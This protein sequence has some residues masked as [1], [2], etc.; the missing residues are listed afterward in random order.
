MYPAFPA[1]PALQPT[2]PC[3][4]PSI[5]LQVSM[6]ILGDLVSLPLLSAMQDLVCSVT[7][8]LDW[9]SETTTVVHR[10]LVILDV[11]MNLEIF[12]CCHLIFAQV[13]FPLVHPPK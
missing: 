12:L 3:G 6:F 7:E 13:K 4:L 5:R 9:T 11:K 10:L 2:L 1:E 8:I